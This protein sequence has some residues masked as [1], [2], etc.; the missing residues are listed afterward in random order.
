MVATEHR[1][2]IPFSLL[3]L[4]VDLNGKDLPRVP[5]THTRSPTL[6]EIVDHLSALTTASLPLALAHSI[7]SGDDWQGLGLLSG[8]R[9]SDIITTLAIC[10]TRYEAGRW[11]NLLQAAIP[12]CTEQDIEWLVSLPAP[13]DSPLPAPQNQNKRPRFLVG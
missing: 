10:G 2:Y 4:L 13:V 3:Q 5:C 1:L 12:G 8:S 7:L 9:L 6:Q 11:I